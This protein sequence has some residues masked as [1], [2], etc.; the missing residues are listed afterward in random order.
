MTQSWSVY[1]GVKRSKV[2][3]RV[4]PTRSAAEALTVRVTPCSKCDSSSGSSGISV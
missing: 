3:V 1:F 4:P 2:K